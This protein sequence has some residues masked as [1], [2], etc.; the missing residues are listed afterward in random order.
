MSSQDSTAV[1]C[2]T[3]PEAIDVEKVLQTLGD[4]FK[5]QIVFARLLKR[6]NLYPSKNFEL[7]SMRKDSI[8][9]VKLNS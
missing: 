8:A 4:G 2:H 1:F 9:E 7:V 5:D 3:L 6:T